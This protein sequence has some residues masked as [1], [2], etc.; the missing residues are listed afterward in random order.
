MNSYPNNNLNNA[1]NSALHQVRSCALRAH[2]MHSCA[3]SLRRS[4]AQHAQV[5]CIAPRSWEQIATSFPRPSPGQVATPFPG[6]DLLDDQARSRRQS[7]VAT[8]LPP[9]QSKS[10]RDLKMGSRHQ[11]PTGQVATSK[12]GRDTNGQCLLLRRQNR[13]S[14]QPGRELNPWSRP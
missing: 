11:V 3:H 5:A 12:W 7:H 8:S 2:G 6:R 10:G 13:S 9:N 4:R 1:K 14:A